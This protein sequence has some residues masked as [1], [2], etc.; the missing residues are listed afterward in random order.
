MFG[1]ANNHMTDFS[2]N[3]PKFINEFSKNNI[4]TIGFGDK[5]KKARLPYINTNENI[6]IL[7]FGWDAIRCKTDGLPRSRFCHL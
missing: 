7:V 5:L 4:N 1:L 3:I 6:V 2:Y